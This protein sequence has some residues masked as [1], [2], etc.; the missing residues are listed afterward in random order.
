M[1]STRKRNPR[2][3]AG[4]PRKN[5]PAGKRGFFSSTPESPTPQAS[6]CRAIADIIVGK[7]HRKDMGDIA[8]LAAN[9]ADVGLLQ[10]IAITPDNRLIDGARRIEAHKL[11]GRTSVPVH[12]IDLDRLARGEYSANV[13]HK[14]FTP[15]EM[16]AIAEALAPI[17]RAKAKERQG[18]R[19]DQHPENFST[20]SGR[21][22][23][24]V[25]VVAGVSRPTL[26]KA[27]AIVE[28]AEAEP[29]KYGKLAADMDR[30]GRINGVYRRLRVAQQAE[31]I[32]AEPP[33]L[34]GKGPYRCAVI[35]FPWADDTGRYDDPSHR[36][37]TPYPPMTLEAICAFPLA[38]I[39]M[40]DAIVWMW[41]T[42][43]HVHRG[44]HRTVLDAL[45]LQSKAMLTWGK[46]HFGGGDWLRGQTEQC[47]LA[48]QGNAVVTLTNQS[49]L[50]LAPP[51]EMGGHSLKPKEFY[52]LVESLCPA[53][54]YADLFSRYQH[55][56]K[57]DCHG[58]KAPSDLSIPADL[59]IPF[60]LRRAL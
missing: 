7:R 31:I 19:T 13:F 58:D 51:R 28:A 24:K 10:P 48:V 16:V 15:S 5:L 6:A 18:Q 55:N 59:S 41:F 50:L 29:E 21:A 22:L 52:D 35:D 46:P 17:E 38:S 43:Y 11:L 2:S 54:R 9:I 30:T 36:L 14:S 37:I 45:G 47:I 42:N 20:S 53:P 39:L 3:G 27:R 33:P 49:T 25:A 32:R 34:P 23:D 56:D 44:I 57:W 26:V 12:V 60:G 1:R 8:E 40:P 4:A